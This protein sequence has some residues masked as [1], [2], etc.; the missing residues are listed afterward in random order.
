MERQ[1]LERG[2]ETEEEESGTGVTPILEML[3]E[4]IIESTTSSWES[5]YLVLDGLCCGSNS[6]RSV[7]GIVPLTGNQ[8]ITKK[9]NCYVHTI[10]G[11]WWDVHC[12]QKNKQTKKNSSDHLGCQEEKQKKQKKGTLSVRAKEE[13]DSFTH[14][15]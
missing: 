13:R 6:N 12:K 5:L 3:P 10:V 11:M 8:I 15:T 9:G 4:Q 2:R 7:Y 14:I 1:G